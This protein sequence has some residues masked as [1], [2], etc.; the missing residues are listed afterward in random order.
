MV[1]TN[2]L[3]TSNVIAFYHGEQICK[4]SV[5]EHRVRLLYDKILLDSLITS[6]YTQTVHQSKA[7]RLRL[8]KS[9]S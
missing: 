4:L 7:V 8:D 6:L 3:Y 2:E 5:K 1:P 9:Y